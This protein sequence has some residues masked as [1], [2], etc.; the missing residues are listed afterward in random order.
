[1]KQINELKIKYIDIGE[2]LKIK[3][4][5]TILYSLYGLILRYIMFYSEKRKR[6][7]EKRKKKKEKKGYVNFFL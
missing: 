6:K 2:N 1:L 4:K 3:K 7:K 5:D